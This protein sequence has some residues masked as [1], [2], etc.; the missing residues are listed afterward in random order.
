T[1]HLEAAVGRLR[2]EG[3]AIELVMLSGVPND[4]GLRLMASCDLVA[5]QFIGG[6][7]GYTAI[8]AMALGKPVLSYVRDGVRIPAAGG[9]PV[10]AANPETLDGVLK[11]L[12]A[13][14]ERL[15]EIGRQSRAYVEAHYSV[16]SVARELRQLYRDSHSTEPRWL[17]PQ[18][19][20]VIRQ[21][22]RSHGLAA[23]DAT[24]VVL[25]VPFWALYPLARA[26]RRYSKALTILAYKG[27]RMALF[28][29]AIAVGRLATAWR[30]GHGTVR[31][32]WGTT[33]ILT[34]PL[35]AACDRRLGLE[36]QSLVFTTYYTAQTFDLNLKPLLD[37]F[38]A[39]TPKLRRVF[40]DLVFAWSLVR[41]DVFHFFCDQGVLPSTGRMGIDPQEARRLRRAGK[42]LYTYTYG[43]DVRTRT[44]TLALGLP[45]FCIDCP[46]PGRFCICDDAAG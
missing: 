46:E 1:R 33:P 31:S 28:E 41:F 8:E 14:P 10:I 21:R 43:A 25:A 23:V 13:A 11:G 22:A 34:L 27:L 16:E 26:L 35:L 18:R 20:E 17:E 24:R 9:C 40:F 36:S 19:G 30:L 7:L 6:S 15:S 45:N 4:E 2:D 38:V 42:R 44:A 29:G 37:R 12:L 3:H 39:R 32:L 5:D